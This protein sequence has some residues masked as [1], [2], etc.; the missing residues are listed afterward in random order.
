MIQIQNVLRIKEFGYDEL[1]A[2]KMMA[3]QLSR[4]SYKKK[5]M[6]LYL[7][8]THVRDLNCFDPFAQIENSKLASEKCESNVDII[9]VS[10]GSLDVIGTCLA[11][12]GTSKRYATKDAKFTLN[13]EIKI[14]TGNFKPES[15]IDYDLVKSVAK[16]LVDW[17]TSKALDLIMGSEFDVKKAIRLGIIDSVINLNDISEDLDCTEDWEE[18]YGN[19][20]WSI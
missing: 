5:P 9:T 10:S 8:G 12:H 4:V 15:I 1:N 2:I 11:M 7:E 16:G 17:D 3:D 19:S 13:P 6:I 18:I 20:F 14:G